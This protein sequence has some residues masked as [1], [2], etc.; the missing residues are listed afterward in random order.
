MDEINAIL[1]ALGDTETYGFI[2][3]SKGIVPAADGWIHFDY[4]PEESNVRMGS[5]ETIGKICV[6]GSGIDEE[7]IKTLFRV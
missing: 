4:V 7:K 6:I 1:K 5:A 2:L 3:R